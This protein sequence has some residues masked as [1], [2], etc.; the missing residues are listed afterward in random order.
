MKKININ[1]SLIKIIFI[2]STI[3][4]FTFS[5][6]AGAMASVEID[7]NPPM[8]SQK[9][10]V[11]FTIIFSD[12]DNIENVRI[13]VEECKE[14]LCYTDNIN[15]SMSKNNE[16]NYEKQ[17][18]LKHN[19]ATFIKYYVEFYENG[20]FVQS[21]VEQVDLE[22]SSNNGDNSGNDTPGFQLFFIII[23]ITLIVLFTRKK[24]F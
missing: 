19:D 8:P 17:V 2:F 7:L 24:R 5:G 18:T 1:K 10:S 9:G 13:I 22:T 16:D 11:E 3:S 23:A 15:E 6:F 21:E 4:V 20:N 14:G 12:N